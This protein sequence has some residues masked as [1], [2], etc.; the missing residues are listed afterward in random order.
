MSPEGKPRMKGMKTM[1]ST[2]IMTRWAVLCIWVDMSH[3][4]VS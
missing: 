1:G 3:V 4:D 2:M